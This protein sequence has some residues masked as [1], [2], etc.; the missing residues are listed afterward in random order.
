MVYEICLLY[1]VTTAGSMEQHTRTFITSYMFQLT[2]SSSG[3]LTVTFACIHLLV[4]LHW[5]VFT[6]YC[7]DEI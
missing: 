6:S 3:I 4:F 5:P 7:D 1:S 2:K